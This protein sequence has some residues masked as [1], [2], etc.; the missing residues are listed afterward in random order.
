MKNDIKKNELVCG[1]EFISEKKENKKLI[2]FII[3]IFSIYYVN[4]IQKIYLEGFLTID[5]FQIFLFCIYL[6]LIINYMNNSFFEKIILIR[7][8]GIQIEEKS[9]FHKKCKF[10]CAN[11]IKS[12]FINEAIYIFEIT[13]YLCIS[14]K[15]NGLIVLFENFDLKL[16]SLVEVY[17]ELQNMFFK[18]KKKFIHIGDEPKVPVD[19]SKNGYD[20]ENEPTEEVNISEGYAS[21]DYENIFQLLEFKSFDNNSNSNKAYEI[22]KNSLRR[23]PNYDIYI[24]KKFAIEILNS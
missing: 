5:E 21:S 2:G 24:D 7:N 9:V 3:L 10:I 12:V 6:F 15:D 16:K 8:I 23:C 13:P 11:D 4:Y 14:L 18:N 19:E 20:K 22:Q 17:R 1:Y